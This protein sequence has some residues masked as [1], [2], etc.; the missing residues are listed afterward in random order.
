MNNSRE[1]NNIKTTSYSSDCFNNATL[2]TVIDQRF[3]DFDAQSEQLSGHDQEYSQLSSGTFAGRFI[4][5]FAG[6]ELSIHCEKANQSLEQWIGCPK[7][8]VSIGIVLEE[9]AGFVVN[10]Q[11][12]GSGDVMITRPGGEMNLS[13]PANGAIMAICID[14]NLLAEMIGDGAGA[15]MLHP[16]REAV[17]T[18]HAPALARHLR[19]DALAVLQALRHNRIEAPS[20][21]GLSRPFVNSITAQLSLHA[22]LADEAGGHTG[23]MSRS[24]FLCAKRLIAE[25]DMEQ[26]DYGRLCAR[27]S[28]SKR[29]IQSAFA[30]Y[31]NTSPS[32]YL[33]T[34][35]LNRTRRALLDR[36]N[37]S[38]SIGD[39]AAANGFWN[40]SR[41]TQEYKALFCELPSQT[42]SK[43]L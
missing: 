1:N 36:S 37:L 43:L 2:S 26:V 30:R 3:D 34:I 31:A 5:A 40:W 29:S 27:T 12:L 24:E 16:N 6:P 42:R 38:D 11:E 23:E 39:I 41:F 21:D 35:K 4:S 17:E 32:R 18:I 15:A 22:A 9:A 8:I 7:G 14:E 13:S 25:G 10:G 33:R 20:S 19:A 28:W